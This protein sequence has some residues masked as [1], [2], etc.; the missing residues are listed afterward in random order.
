MLIPVPSRSPACLSRLW[1]TSVAV[2][3]IAAPAPRTG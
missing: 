1:I 2:V 3:P